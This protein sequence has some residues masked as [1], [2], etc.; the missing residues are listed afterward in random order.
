MRCAEVGEV[1][2]PADITVVEAGHP[3]TALDE[4]LAEPGGP[5][6]HLQAQTH[7][8]Q[9]GLAVGRPL[10]LVRDLHVVVPHGLHRH[11]SSL[12][13]TAVPAHGTYDPACR[14]R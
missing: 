14:R 9:Q 13:R 10:H 5:E 7:D 11:G 1:C 3:E 6:Q 4:Q 8:Q 2:R 12:H